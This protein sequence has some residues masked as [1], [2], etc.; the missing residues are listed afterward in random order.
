MSNKDTLLT[1]MR[2]LFHD[3]DVTALDRYWAEPYDRARPFETAGV[4]GS[5]H[6]PEPMTREGTFPC[7]DLIP[8]GRRHRRIPRPWPS[9]CKP[10]APLSTAPGPSALTCG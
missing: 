5:C 4:P 6:R 3:K 7:T 9:R 10:A 2:E 8:T 1:A